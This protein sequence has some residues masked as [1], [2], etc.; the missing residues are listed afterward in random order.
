MSK[1]ISSQ[2]IKSSTAH[3]HGTP[4]KPMLFNELAMRYVLTQ[5]DN[6]SAEILNGRISD[7]SEHLLSYFGLCP[8]TDINPQRLRKFTYTLETN[9]ITEKKINACLLTF[10][11]CM[12]FGLSHHWITD[13]TMTKPLL[14]RDEFLLPDQPMMSAHEFNDLYQD[15]VQ[16]MTQGAFH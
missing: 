14:N 5:S 2:A 9:G 6:L 3:S 16:G 13:P 15:L 12:R 10:R 1:S 11:T 7:L 4:A 8:I